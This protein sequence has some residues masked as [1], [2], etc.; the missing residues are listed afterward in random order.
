MFDL[1]ACLSVAAGESLSV[2]LSPS[3]RHRCELGALDG[4]ALEQWSPKVSPKS[5]MTVLASFLPLPP[6]EDEKGNSST[7]S[8]LNY[9]FIG[10]IQRKR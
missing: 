3:G 2:R 6:R 9:S 4:V 8:P 7:L 10:T 5:I 1:L